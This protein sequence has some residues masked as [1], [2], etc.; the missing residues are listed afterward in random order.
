[1]DFGSAYPNTLDDARIHLG[2]ESITE[3]SLGGIAPTSV[4]WFLWCRPFNY[5]FMHRV[6]RE[7]HSISGGW[8]GFE[9]ALYSVK[10]LRKA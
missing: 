1:M 4:E 10:F 8:L 6:P 5:T 9:W 3:Q 7:A 2:R